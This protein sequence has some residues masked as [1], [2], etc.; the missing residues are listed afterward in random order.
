MT[1]NTIQLGQTT[2]EQVQHID[3]NFTQLFNKDD[4]NDERFAAIESNVE[5]NQKNI[6]GVDTR[7][8][9]VES[10]YITKAVSDLANY[11][12]KTQTD[13]TITNLQNQI[14]QIPK[15]SISVVTS[16]PT[17]NI[18]T[19]TIYLVKTGDDANNLYTEY[20]YVNNKWEQIGTQKLDLSGYATLDTNQDISGT[21]T[22]KES[23][24]AYGRIIESG[25]RGNHIIFGVKSDASK[26]IGLTATPDGLYYGNNKLLMY[27]DM[28][29]YDTDKHSQEYLDAIDLNTLKGE[30]TV[31]WYCRTPAAVG[32][33]TNKPVDTKGFGLEVFLAGDGSLTVQKF[34][35][36]SD[37]RIYVRLWNASSW[38]PW[39][40]LAISSEIP[41]ASTTTPKMNGTASVG[42]ATTFARADHVHPTDTSRASTAVATTSANGLM[43]RTDKS[44][45]DQVKG[46]WDNVVVSLSDRVAYGYKTTIKSTSSDWEEYELNG[47]KYYKHPIMVEGYIDYSSANCNIQSVCNTDNGLG[48]VYQE[49]REDADGDTSGSKRE[50]NIVVSEKM[51]LAVRYTRS[52]DNT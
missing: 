27:A 34:T 12:T 10:S 28:A 37:G 7:L 14:S 47:T 6:S 16:L 46:L 25:V 20:I 35:D 11:Y 49:L 5:T 41:D 51:N 38:T 13:A 26:E 1:Q 42:T 9:T 44:F 36:G 45:L 48:I 18:S 40:K 32:D 21:K 24:Y 23:I 33:C 22:F 4:T 29:S 50:L 8:K 39:V 43:S 17:S 3:D 31:G 30:E 19:T 15:F 2:I 52:G